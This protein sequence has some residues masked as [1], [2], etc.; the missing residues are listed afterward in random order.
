MRL[1]TRPLIARAAIAAAVS[2]A[3]LAPARAQL[4]VLPPHSTVAGEPLGHWT[5]YFWQWAYSFSMPHDPFSD[6]AGAVYASQ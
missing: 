5:A 4:T 2:L 1:H 3:P 6:P